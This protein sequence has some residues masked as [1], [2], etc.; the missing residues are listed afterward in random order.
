MEPQTDYDRSKPRIRVVMFPKDT[1]AMGS[2]FGGVI[3]SHIDLAAAQEAR[4]V[5][6]Q[7][8]VTKIFREVNFV[9]PV[10]VG[11][12]LSCYAKVTR[13]GRTSVT[14]K[15]LAEAQRALS[16]EFTTVTEAEVVMVAVNEKGE[17][18]EIV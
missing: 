4:D 17:P 14:I 3:L 16:R 13:R 1:N 8:F 7:I 15:V 18:V 5:S 11:D 6:P 10:G 2:I 9:A 12:T